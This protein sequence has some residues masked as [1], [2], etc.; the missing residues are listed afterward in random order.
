MLSSIVKEKR[1]GLA[2][3]DLEAQVQALVAT[4]RAA[5]PAIALDDQR[6]VAHL[7]DRLPEDADATEVF[8]RL[9]ATD[10]FLA[11]ACLHGIA[12]ATAAFEQKYLVQ[13]TNVVARVDSSFDAVDEVRQR[14]R[15]R[16]FVGSSAR[17]AEYS[18]AG[19]LSSWVRVAA[20]RLALN[21]RREAQRSARPHAAAPYSRN[22]EA[23]LINVQ[24]RHEVETAFRMAFQRLSSADREI[25]RLYYCE[26]RKQAE[27]A[28]R[29]KI[30]R[31]TATRRIET[32]RRF[33]LQETR[34]EFERLVPAITTTSRDSLLFAL[35][36]QLDLNLES[37]LRG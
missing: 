22:P 30:E 17:I 15:E 37:L 35:R 8:E 20:M 9:H 3:I 26:G 13:V 6:F 32:A 7:A 16:L 24:Y 11:C 14:L 36:S 28:N 18:G 27:I 5:W 2:H 19:P 25:L 34:R 21:M 23:D 12:Q 33:L 4:A 29:L 31:S 1:P 10:L